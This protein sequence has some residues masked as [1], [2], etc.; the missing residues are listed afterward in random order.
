[1]NTEMLITKLRFYANEYRRTLIGR[2]IEG[3]EKLLDDAADALERLA[4]YEDT[5][6]EPEAILQLKK[7]LEIFNCDD[8]EPEQLTQM[9]IK[10]Q[11]W[12]D[13]E[14]DGRLVVQKTVPGTQVWVLAR[15]ECGNP[16]EIEG[17]MFLASAGQSVIVSPYIDDIDDLCGVIE[18]H[19]SETA[20]NYDT[21][22]SVFPEEDCYLTREEAEAA[23]EAQK[24]GDA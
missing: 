9:L 4:A 10:L 21:D 15:D 3:K 12:A 19:I 11:S 7:I 20:E 1:M 14:L 16:D 22:L 2:E 8:G 13:A 17:Y 24:G 23:L 18:Y 5:G 6:L